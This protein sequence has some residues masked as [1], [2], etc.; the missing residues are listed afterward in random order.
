LG[1]G[2]DPTKSAPWVYNDAAVSLLSPI[3]VH[4]WNTPIETIAKR[5]LLDPLGVSQFAVASDR[6][7]N[8]MSHRGLRL[9]A[10]DFTKLAWTMANGG[11]WGDQQVVPAK[12]VGKSTSTHVPTTWGAAPMRRAGYDYLWFTGTPS[13]RPVAWAWGYGAQFALIVPSLRLAVTTTAI[14]PRPADL[15]ARSNAVMTVVARIVALA[16]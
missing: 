9:R 10:R 2:I 3:L 14:N 7:G 4:A 6:T 12:W 16:G 13:G 8:V 1:L 15:L 11:R 5:D